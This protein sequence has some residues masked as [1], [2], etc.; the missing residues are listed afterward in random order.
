MPSNSRQ[1][2][3]TINFELNDR[4]K[5]LLNVSIYDLSSSNR[6]EAEVRKK[7]R[8]VVNLTTEE[9][10]LFIERS[11]YGRSF[12]DIAEQFCISINKCF[13]Q[14]KKALTKIEKAVYEKE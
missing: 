4:S 10:T 3:R 5:G 13:R 6:D 1:Q 12:R 2:L 7:L 11:V 8:D 9:E 14:Y